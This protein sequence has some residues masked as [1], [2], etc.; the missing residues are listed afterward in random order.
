[1]S[2]MPSPSDGELI[3]ELVETTPWKGSFAAPLA[4]DQSE[5][6]QIVEVMLEATP[7]EIEVTPGHRVNLWT[8]NG[9]LPGP[10]IE[11]RVGDTL[12]VRFR[13]SLPE[14]TTIHWHGL[15]VP[16]AMDGVT[17]V[18]AAI[19]PGEEFTYE[20]VLE[21]SGTFWYHP[22]VRSDEQVERGLYGAIVVRDD[23]EPVLT[24]ENTVVLDDVLLDADWQLTDFSDRQAM[25]GRQGNLILVNGHAAPQAE[26]TAGG[27]HRIRFVNAANARYFRLALDD[28]RL[29]ILGFDGSKLEAPVPAEEVLLVPGARVDLAFEGAFEGEALGWSALSYERGHETGVAA[30]TRLFEMRFEGEQA[31]VPTLPSSL[32]TLPTLAEPVLSRSLALEESDSSAGPHAGHGGGD[33]SAPIFSINGEVFPTIE[34]LTATLDTTEEWTIEN[35]TMMDHPFHLHGFRFEVTDVNGKAPAYRA[36]QDTINVPAEQIVT[37]RVP[38]QGHAGAWMFHCHILEHAE[39]GMMGELD[40]AAP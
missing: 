12:R 35:T 20:F 9:T 8:Y 33:A 16:S 29:W 40:V 3:P 22:H 26:L 2:S 13:N 14:A 17:A 30:D 4:E 34:P 32:A 15:R 27:L 31:P 23:D 24:S 11:A 25:I 10:T 19:Q 7:A 5:E 1:M 36:L 39:R 21:D 18:Q 6:P 28:R 37:I 38:L